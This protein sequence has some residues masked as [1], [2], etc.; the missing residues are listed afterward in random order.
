MS[1]TTPG[2]TGIPKKS[3]QPP[4]VTIET[5]MGNIVVELYWKHAPNTC[6]NFAELTRRGYYN[7]IKFHRIIKDFMIQGG[8]PT[9]TGRGGASI[10]GKNFDD[11]INEDLKHTGAGILS[12]ANS[13]P[14][15][16]GSQFF[17]TLAPTQWLDGKHTIFGRVSSGIN[18]I[19]RIGMVET[20]DG[21][22]PVDPVKIH[23]AY[24]SP[25]I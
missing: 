12:M 21:D 3:W 15:T 4:N 10:Y 23:K 24:I 2:N 20:D 9:G 17:I 16:N 22:K 13:G 19:Q 1:L 18:V 7:G 11:E 8:D 14:N 6:R 5:T 25:T